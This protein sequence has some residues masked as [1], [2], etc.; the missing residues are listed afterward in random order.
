MDEGYFSQTRPELVT[1]VPL[2]ARRVLDVGCGA[3]RFGAQLQARGQQVV[4]IEA[5]GSVA[6]LAADALDE[7]LVMDLDDS[8]SVDSFAEEY[9]EAFGCLVAA[10]V[11]EH[12]RDPW[13]VLKRLVDTVEPGG[14]VVVSVP[15]VRLIWVI[16]PLVLRGRFQYAPHGVLDQTHLRF[17][18]RSSAEQLVEGVGLTIDAVDRAPTPW[19]TGA[20][21]WIGRL[22]GDFGNEQF[23]ITAHRSG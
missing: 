7:V 5:D 23:L 11:L 1:R 21:A 20:K 17:F 18:T 10:D 9:E 2:R 22:I 19:R 6:R 3:G 13:S 8:D 4:G 12:L 16:A 15:N 14:T